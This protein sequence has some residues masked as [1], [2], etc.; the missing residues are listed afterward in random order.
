MEPLILL[1][2][3][4]IGIFII[5]TQMELRALKKHFNQHRDIYVPSYEELM[6]MNHWSIQLARFLIKEFRKTKN[7]NISRKIYPAFENKNDLSILA[8]ASN[9]DKG[10]TNLNNFNEFE[11][12][13]NQV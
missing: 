10:K 4:L 2:I 7:N 8:L 11:N 13:A 1:A 6:R 12:K 9:S 5:R 3:W